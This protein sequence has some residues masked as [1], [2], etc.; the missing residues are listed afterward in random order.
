MTE[1]DVWRAIISTLKAGLLAQGLGSVEV[2]QNFQ[3]T[4][5]GANIAP[6]VYIHKITTGLVGQQGVKYDYN[7]LNAN[8]DET[9][10]Q[11]LAPLF[12]L[13]AIVA[14]D[15]EDV[16][17]LTAGGLIGTCAMIMQGRTARQLLLQAGIGIERVKE[18]R[19][20]NRIDDKDE[21]NQD[22]SFDFV[23]SYK[24]EISGTAP[25]AETI[26]SNF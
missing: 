20:A 2:K 16:D 11:W 4:S 8:F 10:S 15:I 12:Q 6:T 14:Q 26:E 9:E 22:P 19:D 23:L 5:Q 18:I 17:S 25:A 24:Q 7:D 21:F 3:P 1:S 13:S